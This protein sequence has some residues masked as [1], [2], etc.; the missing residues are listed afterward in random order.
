MH[1]SRSSRVPPQSWTAAWAA[2]LELYSRE[3]PSSSSIALSSRSS[4]SSYAS[5][6]KDFS[7]RSPQFFARVPSA[8]CIRR[9]SFSTCLLTSGT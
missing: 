2:P 3:F 8:F 6:S 9:R 1:A 5:F 4:A 7:A